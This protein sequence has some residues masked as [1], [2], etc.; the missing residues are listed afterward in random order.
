M[1]P[2]EPRELTLQRR[3]GVFSATT[4]ISGS[5][6]GSGIFIAPSIM[7]GYIASPCI[8]LGLWIAGGVLTLLGALSY[9]ELSAMMPRAGGQYVFLREAFGPRVAFLYGWT[10]F[11]VIQTGFNAAVAIAFAKFLGGVGLRAG[12]LDVVFS[13]GAFALSR[14]QIVA[15]LVIALLTWVNGQGLRE[16][17]VVQNVFTVMKI[18][19]IVLLAIGAFA[20]GKGSLDHFASKGAF[21]LGPK[22]VAL[23]LSAAMGVAMSKALFATTRGTRSRLPR[24]KSAS[25][26]AI[27]LARSL[28]ARS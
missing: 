24:K 13:I 25:R 6:I 23:G 8:W 5:M 9:A 3:L 4:I 1:P 16:G 21:E 17:A 20:S 15:V 2:S 14:A 27:C 11:L 26:S 28:R 22:G 18:G 19:A 7:A 12:E 10:F